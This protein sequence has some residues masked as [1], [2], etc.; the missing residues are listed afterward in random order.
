MRRRKPSTLEH[1]SAQLGR[2][3]L[4]FQARLRARALTLAQLEAAN[5][6]ALPPASR[7]PVPGDQRAI[8]AHVRERAHELAASGP[9]VE[10]RKAAAV[11]VS[12]EQLAVYHPI[13]L[14]DTRSGRRPVHAKSCPRCGRTLALTH[15]ESFDRLV[16]FVVPVHRWQ[17]DTCGW[18]GLLIDRHELKL[19]KRRLAGLII[20]VLAFLLGLAIMWY[21]DYR[22]YSYR[23]PVD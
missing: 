3:P 12:D 6:S 9:A 22:H 13:G 1:A 16:T 4:A 11:P 14:A 8:R 17:C 23:P 21:L 18:R 15:R 5:K 20:I 2:R 19:L 7:Q 10:S